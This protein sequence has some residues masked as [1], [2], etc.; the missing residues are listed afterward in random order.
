MQEQHH[1]NAWQVFAP[2][3]GAR[4][5]GGWRRL[6]QEVVGLHAMCVILGVTYGSY[7]NAPVLLGVCSDASITPVMGR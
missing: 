7:E 3:I 6:K 5:I 1:A 4:G 2:H